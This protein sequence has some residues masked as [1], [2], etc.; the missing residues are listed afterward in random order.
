MRESVRSGTESSGERLQANRL[1]P[2][3]SLKGCHVDWMDK[4][5][6]IRVNMLKSN[7]P[8]SGEHSI[9]GRNDVIRESCVRPELGDMTTDL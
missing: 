9:A 7:R 5:C 6:H 1:P 4:I 8:E 3:R 2:P